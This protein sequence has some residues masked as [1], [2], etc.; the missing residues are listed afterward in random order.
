MGL[1]LALSLT[2]N[3]TLNLTRYAGRFPPK[4]RAR[5]KPPEGCML[6]SSLEAL[7]GG[8]RGW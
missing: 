2:L 4:V 3:P 8:V 7:P 5:L 6:C 1:G